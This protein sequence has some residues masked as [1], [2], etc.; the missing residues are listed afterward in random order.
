MVEFADG[1]VKAQMGPPDMRLPIQYALLHPNRL[2]NRTLARYDPVQVP[3]LTFD[4][5]D[6][7]RYPCFRIAL[8]AGRRG[9]TF[10]AVLS[11]AADEAVKLF[12]DGHISFGAIAH[13]VEETLE[14]HQP[15]AGSVSLEAVLEADGWARRYVAD[16]ARA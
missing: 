8:D 12:L 11:A 15:A 1:S 4:P 9:G 5:L 2:A 14:A 16:H 6:T 3:T 13:L 7:E 10:P